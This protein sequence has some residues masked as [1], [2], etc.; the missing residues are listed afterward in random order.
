MQQHKIT[1]NIDNTSGLVCDP[2][3][4]DESISVKQ[5]RNIT[6]YPHQKNITALSHGE[7]MPTT[8]F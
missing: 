7:V 4:I 5:R 1:Q 8:I 6:L 3:N 2:S